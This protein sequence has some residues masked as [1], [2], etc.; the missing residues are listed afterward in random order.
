MRVWV[1]HKAPGGGIVGTVAIPAVD[2]PRIL[3]A[4][5]DD[6]QDVDAC[7]IL[8][9]EECLLPYPSSRFLVA[10]GGGPGNTL[11]VALPQVGMPV[12]AGPAWTWRRRGCWTRTAA[13]S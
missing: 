8:N 6:L 10:T 5:I 1:S 4:Q 9:N 11:Q 7:E 3:S 2:G 13:A 12:L